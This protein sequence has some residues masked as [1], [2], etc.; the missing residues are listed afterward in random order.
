VYVLLLDPA[1]AK[2]ITQI[3]TTA[4]NGSY[5]WRYSGVLPP[6]IQ[7]LAGT[8]LDNDGYVCNRGEVCGAYPLLSEA[9]LP[10]ISITADRS[11]L[12]F[13]MAPLGGL[14]TAATGPLS[15]S[16]GYPLLPKTAAAKDLSP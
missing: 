2:P 3:K 16:K 10:L 13:G 14:I 1:K 8:D 9:E 6:K 4:V 15:T 5:A 11:D 7:I 12:N